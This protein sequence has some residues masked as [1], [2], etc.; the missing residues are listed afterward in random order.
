MKTKTKELRN[1]IIDRINKLS[2][3]KLENVDHFIDRIEK[4]N[5]KEEILSYAGSWEDID[6]D[7]FKE[8][9][10]DLHQKRSSERK[11]IP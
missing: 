8:L 1:R 6:D 10:M 11:R 5:N 4:I 9:T 7:L 3:E 2:T